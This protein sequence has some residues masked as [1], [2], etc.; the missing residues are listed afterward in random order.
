MRSVKNL[1][2][3]AAVACATL[4]VV[5]GATQAAVAS[6]AT[7]MKFT[8][9]STEVFEGALPECFR[10]DLVGTNVVT[11]TATGQFVENEGGVFTVHGTDV[12]EY[13]VDFPNGMY[14][15][16]T[17]TDHFA[18]VAAGATVSKDVVKETRTVYQS[19][20]TP[21]ADVVIHAV[22]HLTYR[23]RNGDGQPQADEIS[24]SVDRFF[25]TCH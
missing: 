2:R 25:F 5:A 22:G 9:V 4:L 3:A 12:F 17:G 20:G 7:V 24:A 8:N 16:G 6:G 21:V 11:D 13:R 23:D 10:S 15:S 18:F 14:A 19:D 1:G